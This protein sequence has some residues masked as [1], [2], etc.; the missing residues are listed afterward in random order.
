MTAPHTA[1]VAAV[2]IRHGEAAAGG[3][4]DD[5]AMQKRLNSLF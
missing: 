2:G 4:G 1:P 5:A 3:R